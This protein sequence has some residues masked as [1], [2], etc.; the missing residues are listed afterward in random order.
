MADNPN[1]PQ[2]QV[3]STKTNDAIGRRRALQAGT[4]VAATALGIAT[5]GGQAAAHFPTD[6]EI[7]IRPG[8]GRAPINPDSHGIVPVAVLRTD[9]FD[10]ASEPV[11]YR[12]GAPDVVADGGGARPIDDGHAIDV[13]GDGCADRLLFFRADETGFDGD[14]SVGRL[15]WERTE[16]GHH[17]LAGTGPVTIVG[18]HYRE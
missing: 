1:N 11:R 2:R 10:P 12:F 6:L 9:E 8:G 7:D 17:G 14:E 4:G 5:L 3:D 15:E 16:D 13:T 18:R